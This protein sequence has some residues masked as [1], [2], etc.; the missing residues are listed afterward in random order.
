MTEREL[1]SLSKKQILTLLT[2]QDNTLERLAKELEQ[3]KTEHEYTKKELL[4]VTAELAAAKQQVVELG[5]SPTLLNDIVRAANE[6]ADKYISE[7]EKEIEVRMQKLKDFEDETANKIKSVESQGSL[8]IS[9]ICSMLDKHIEN[10]HVL[11]AEFHANLRAVNMAQFL[12][13]EKLG[14]GIGDSSQNTESTFGEH[15]DND[16]DIL[17]GQFEI[18]GTGINQ[19]DVDIFGDAENIQSDNDTFDGTVSNQTDSNVFGDTETKQTD[20]NAFGD[21]E[22]NIA[23]NDI[24]GGVKNNQLDSTVFGSYESNQTDNNTFSGTESSKTAS[25]D[26][27]DDDIILNNSA[28][29]EGGYDFFYE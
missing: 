6:T 28:K 5:A 16:G 18:E 4:N 1:K 20:N 29:V 22:A 8:V 15:F 17:P 2:K 7:A 26:D 19:T 3:A 11:Y 12:P 13:P 25:T 14:M 24:F 27:D 23:D 9:G 10:V 21:T